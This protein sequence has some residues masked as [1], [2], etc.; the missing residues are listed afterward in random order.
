[1]KLE[2]IVQADHA[3]QIVAALWGMLAINLKLM[4]PSWP[5]VYEV[6]THYK[7][8][9]EGKEEWNTAGVIRHRP[10]AG[11]DCEDLASYACAWNIVTGFDPG[12]KIGLRR[13]SVGYHVIVLRSDGSVEDPSRVL[14]M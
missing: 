1:M 7:R 4:D 12:S 9:R 3:D 2:L 10:R 14:G 8:E 5:S 11:Y 6:G 13:S